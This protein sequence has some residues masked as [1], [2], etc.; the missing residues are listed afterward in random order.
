MVFLSECSVGNEGGPS[1]DTVV[2]Q[3][4]GVSVNQLPWPAFLSE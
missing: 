1:C 2:K 3:G 4:M